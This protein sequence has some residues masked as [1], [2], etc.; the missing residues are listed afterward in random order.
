MELQRQVKAEDSLQVFVKLARATRMTADEH[1]Q[2]MLHT[3]VLKVELDEGAKA[4][5]ELAQ[6]KAEH[7]KCPKQS[8]GTDTPSGAVAGQGDGP[9]LGESAAAVA[10]SQE[11]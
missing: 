10:L 4:K 5:A 2:F 6:L 9:Q 8:S 1:E 11:D 3:Q 7:D